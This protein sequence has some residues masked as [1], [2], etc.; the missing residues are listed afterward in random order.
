MKEK[1]EK[2]II[3]RTIHHLARRKTA[4][5]S[6]FV[7]MLVLYV[8]SSVM[9]VVSATS[10]GN[11]KVLGAS[12]PFASF[13][14]V[15]SSMSSIC[16]ILSTFYFGKIGYFTSLGLQFLQLPLL[17]IRIMKMHAVMNIP[18][19]FLNLMTVI[20]LSIIYFNNNRMDKYQSVMME[21]AVTD[22]LTGLPNRF[23]ISELLKTL[24][25]R[26][27]PFALVVIN[28][29]GFKGINDTLGFE[30]GNDVLIEIASRWKEIAD[31]GKSG[32]H[33]YI[34]RV[35][36]DE[37]SLVI[38]KF[39]TEED[40]L[41]TI[42]QY[43]AVLLKRLT[44]DDC[45]LYLSASFGYAMF[46]QDANSKDAMI[47]CGEAA[48]KEVKRVNSSNHVLHF[49]PEFLQTERTVEIA[50]KI[51]EA[52]ENETIFYNLQPQF[53]IY[54]KLRGFEALARMKDADGTFISPAEFIP[55]AEKVGLVDKVDGMVFRKS[56][57]FFG[58]LLRAT[59]ADITL[60][61]NVSVRHLMKNDFIDE[62]REVLKES[63]VPA[64]NLEIE[65]TESIM[66]DSVDKALLCIDEIRKIGLQIAIDDFGTGYSSLSYLN[67]F[68]ADLLKVDK[69]FVDRMN[70]S[71]SSR[72]YVSAIIS[73][74]HIMG[75]DVIA[76]G[77]EEA[78]QVETLKEIGC[79]FI[80]GFIWGKPL[81]PEF[82]EKL[83]MESVKK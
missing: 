62:I 2:K 79:D 47:L 14:G 57:M 31:N 26:N 82:A 13:T 77:V 27:E 83:V 51:R 73:I 80:Q 21:Q 60:S 12:I 42:R 7:L 39:Q 8:I 25:D 34:T 24:V 81:T 54:H 41:N 49:S 74:G 22:R 1:Q 38:R 28:I 19:L 18:G 33:D 43:E 9:T 67:K 45:D 71:D 76:E 65:I 40:I 36:G 53:D 61:V 78:D 50:G 59:G 70:T 29:N 32:T 66:I 23:A 44:V 52:L 11:F 20:A 72:Q 63:G 17:L 55:V 68:P 37:F 4:P 64:R 16:L 58:E 5:V 30:T 35:S 15:F 48:M 46:P 3:E 6:F 69:S 56:A 10:Q 75:F